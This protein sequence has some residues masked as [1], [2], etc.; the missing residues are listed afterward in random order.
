M[1]L[2]LPLPPTKAA[3][4]FICAFLTKRGTAIPRALK[5]SPRWSVLVV[6]AWSRSAWARHASTV[7]PPRGLRAGASYSGQDS[8]ENL[9]PLLQNLDV[10]LLPNVPHDALSFTTL[11]TLVG[12]A[13]G[14]S[15]VGDT[16]GVCVVGA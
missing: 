5:A 10:R 12:T 11:D 14:A 8:K 2:R 6:A 7:Q 1:A 3:H 15:V 13:V 16:V 9:G 4:V